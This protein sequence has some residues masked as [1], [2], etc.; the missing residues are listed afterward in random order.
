M[1]TDFSLSYILIYI[2][3]N[4]FVTLNQNESFVIL[5]RELPKLRV[6]SIQRPR[7]R[8]SPVL[9]SAAISGSPSTKSFWNPL[10]NNMI[11]SPSSCKLLLPLTAYQQEVYSETA[12][13]W[14]I[15]LF[16]IHMR[17]KNHAYYNLS[18]RLLVLCNLFTD[19]SDAL[20]MFNYTF[21]GRFLL[22]CH[23]SMT[24]RFRI[25]IDTLV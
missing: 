25:L 23:R 3:H 14:Q 9:D 8:R 12:P 21:E 17:E 13:V 24:R 22:S 7:Y 10:Q 19:N 2:T 18:F 6:R 15:F 1:T 20:P 16:C 4:F 5:V 11:M